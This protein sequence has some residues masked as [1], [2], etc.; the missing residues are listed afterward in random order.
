MWR[1]IDRAR[2]ASGRQKRDAA[3]L[4]VTVGGGW[5]PGAGGLPSST[6]MVVLSTK[7]WSAGAR[8][9]SGDGP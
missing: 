7:A 9:R 4:G 2:M 8:E 1:I 5:A 6:A 3:L